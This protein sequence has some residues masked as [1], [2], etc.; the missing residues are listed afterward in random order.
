[1]RSVL[2]KKKGAIEL[3]MTTV[4]VIVLSMTMLA[5]GLT[6]VRTLFQGATYTAASLNNQVQ[7]QLNQIFSQGGTDLLL[8]GPA[9]RQLGVCPNS[10][11]F[12]HYY[13]NTKDGGIIKLA[14]QNA[15]SDQIQA[16]QCTGIEKKISS[17]LSVPASKVYGANTIQK[18]DTILL[19]VPSTIPSGCN[20][21]LT[22]TATWADG[23]SD[24][25]S[26]TV[27]TKASSIAGCTSD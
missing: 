14:I 17:R 24:S 5:L 12:V 23:T 3:S 22:L 25:T 10:Q 6:L 27:Q 16:P 7:D 13:L 9:N 15:A 19:T 2:S 4:V 20:F 1:M 21:F 8:V 18:T 26:M 11:P